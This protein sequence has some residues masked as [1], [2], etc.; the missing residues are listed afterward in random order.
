MKVLVLSNSPLIESQGSGYVILNFVRG[1]QERGHEID[2][3]GPEQLEPFAFLRKAK[4]HRISLGMLFCA[5]RQIRRKKYDVVEFYGGESWLAAWYLSR[6]RNRTFLL[7]SHSNGIETHTREILEKHLPNGT[8]W[9]GKPLRWYQKLLHPPVEH[10][11]TT[12]DA[13]VTVSQFDRDYAIAVGYQTPEHVAAFENPLPDEF[14][15]LETPFERPVVIGYCG[16]WLPRK[17]NEIIQTDLTRILEEFPTSQLKLIGV[18]N[19]FQKESVFPA[20]ICSRIEVL[21]SVTRAELIRIYQSI[22]VLAQPSIY[23]SFG[24]VAAEAMACGCAL[25]AANTGFASSLCDRDQAMLMEQPAAPFLYRCVRELLLDEPLRQRIA[26]AGHA[27]VQSL[28]WPET[29]ERIETTYRTW[30]REFR[31]KCAP[32]PPCNSV[33]TP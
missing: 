2:L 31:E 26:R 1:L 30:L 29:I 9:D 15:A 5:V 4:S 17:G 33:T 12:V 3:F 20:A 7:V 6:L 11:F 19:D 24:L 18:G 16:S 32:A 25:V 21:P 22:A 14:L 13:V 10:A 28:R 27:R 8:S 23:E